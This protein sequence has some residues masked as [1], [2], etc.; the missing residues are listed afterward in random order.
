MKKEFFWAY[1]LKYLIAFWGGAFTL[2]L[3][4]V[5]Q[6]RFLGLKTISLDPRSYIVPILFGGSAGL[7]VAIFYFRLKK[8]QTQL[9]DY[10]DHIDN[11]VQIISTAQRFLYVNK[12]WL[13]TLQYTPDEVKKLYLR[14]ILHPDKETE[15]N[16]IFERVFAGEKVGEIETILIAKDGSEIYVRGTTNGTG[17]EGPAQKTRGIFKNITASREAEEFQRLSAKFFENTQDALLVTDSKRIILSVNKAFTE[18]SGYSAENIL[19]KDVK[20]LFFYEEESEKTFQAILNALAEEKNWRGEL[21]TRKKNDSP[22]PVSISISA[23]IS[24]QGEINN[25]IY[26]F[27]DISERKKTEEKLTQMAWHDTLTELPN[28][29]L[30]QK[31]IT[32]A[33]QE[34]AQKQRRFAVFFLDLDGFKSINDQYGHAKG[35]QILQMVA[36]RLEGS[37]RQIDIVARLGGDEFGVLLQ[38][39][40]DIETVRKTAQNLSKKINAPYKLDEEQVQLSASIGISFYPE[41]DTLEDLLIA[42]DTAMY[43]AKKK[44]QNYIHFATKD[45]ST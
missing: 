30:F 6:K 18:I 31:A 45:G 41:Y 22:Y 35:D 44:P 38:K 2:S 4:S 28:R 26:L 42:A 32:N 33:I 27:S 39:T 11:L 19:G 40:G 3:F 16:A 25:Y 20:K 36:R 14:D 7:I 15:C 43:Q 8:N 34:Y 21:W 12:A 17:K 23:V 13:D 1:F 37:L 9:E 10:L 29:L 24:Q 5:L